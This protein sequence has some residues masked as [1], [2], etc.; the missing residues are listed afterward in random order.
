VSSLVFV[1][2]N[3]WLVLLP[4]VETVV[5]LRGKPDWKNMNILSKKPTNASDCNIFLQFRIKFP[6]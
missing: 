1:G 4:C 3:N 6:I 5:P 2:E